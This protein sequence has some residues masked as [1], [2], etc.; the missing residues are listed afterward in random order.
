MPSYVDQLGRQVVLH[1]FPPRRIVSVVPSQTELL[2]ALGLEE[3]VVGITKFCVHPEPWRRLKVRVGGTKQLHLDRIHALAP[4]LILANK[5][6]NVREQIQALARH[7]PVWVS[8]VPHLEAACDMI[9][10]VGALV[11]RAAAATRLVDRIR[12]GFARLR[13]QVA[14]YPPVRVAYFIWRKPWMVAAGGTFIHSV[15]SAA[16][17]VNVFAHRARYPEV[18]LEEVAQAAPQVLL[19]SSEPFPFADKHLRELAELLP[20]IPAVRVDG[21]LCS[22]YGSRLLYTPD[23]LAQLHHRLVSQVS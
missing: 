23:Y 11:G 4:D 20:H 12:E 2:A 17:L 22:W 10:R 14:A 1:T 18:Q 9:G 8:D 16:G 7:Y 13:R 6:E 15:L 19:L 3:E 5:E 21:Q